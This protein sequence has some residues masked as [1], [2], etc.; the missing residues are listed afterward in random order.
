MRTP[1]ADAVALRFNAR[2]S[3]ELIPGFAG[4]GHYFVRFAGGR[5]GVA[6]LDRGEFYGAVYTPGN[7]LD[8]RSI[9]EM[10]RIESPFK[11]GSNA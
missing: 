6:T 7:W 1:P 3:P 11:E 8:G 4:D 5:E 10:R 9:E 2:V